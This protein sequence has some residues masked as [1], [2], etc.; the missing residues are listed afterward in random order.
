MRMLILGASGLV[1]G[2]CL[3]HFSAIPGMTVV[4]TYFSFPVEGTVFYDTLNP[5]HPDQFDAESFKP[6]VVISCGA[7]THVDYCESN[8]DESFSKTVLSN[9]TALQLAQKCGAVFVYI[10]TDY[11]FDGQNGPYRETDPVHP[12]SV[13]ASH[14]LQAEQ[15]SMEYSDSL[16]LRI[17]NV[18]GDEIRGKNFVSRII[19]QAKAGQKLTLKLPYDQYATPVNAYDIARALELLLRDGK[20]GIYHIAG[21]DFLNRVELALKVLTYFPGAEYE[22]IPM[23]TPSLAQPAA[24]P[25]MG[26]LITAKFSSEYPDFLFESVDRYV[27]RK[28]SE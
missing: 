28:L 2:N 18:Y 5:N 1:G 7:L 10:S 24:R 11:V 9:R 14:K 6:D 13:Y 22:L 25:L 8:P 12:I 23:D 3:K 16:I 26:G 20:R 15:E 19:D 17:T 4:G 21:T 27:Q